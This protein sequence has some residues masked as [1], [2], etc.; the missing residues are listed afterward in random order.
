VYPIRPSSSFL[1][2]PGSVR[3]RRDDEGAYV[4]GPIRAGV[5]LN[6]RLASKD[7]AKEGSDEERAGRRGVVVVGGK[8]G[9]KKEKPRWV[10]P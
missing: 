1:L 3:H 7:M 4:M 9:R 2:P 8:G 5:T 10:F 6:P